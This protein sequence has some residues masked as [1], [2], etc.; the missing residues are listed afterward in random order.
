LLWGRPQDLAFEQIV[1]GSPRRRHH[2][3]LWQV[4]RP[5]D[6]RNTLWIGAATYD[7]RVGFSR[8]TGEIIHHIEPR[9]DAE[10]DRLIEDLGGAGRLAGVD[11]VAGFRAAGRDRNGSGD[12]YETDGR[13][14]VAV[15]RAPGSGS[16]PAPAPAAALQELR[17]AISRSWTRDRAS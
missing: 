8:Y 2:V 7:L 10:R 1:D 14:C 9:V 6:P 12:D 13:L 17:A 11:C 5:R 16:P 15:L 4:N 3:R